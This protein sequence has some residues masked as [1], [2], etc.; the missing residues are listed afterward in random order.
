MTFS[1]PNQALS[2]LLNKAEIAC[3]KNRRSLTESIY[4]SVG[5]T[6]SSERYAE[7]IANHLRDNYGYNV[8]CRHDGYGFAYQFEF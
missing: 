3:Q 2:Y 7:S 1:D 6:W 8:V 5:D 4:L